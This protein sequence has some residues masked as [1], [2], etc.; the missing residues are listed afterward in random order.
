MVA[1]RFSPK[2]THKNC[3]GFGTV[4]KLYTPLSFREGYY[5]VGGTFNNSTKNLIILYC[6]KVM[7]D[8]CKFF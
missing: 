6:E 3:F 1:K 4:P 8:L 5:I 7:E 2:R